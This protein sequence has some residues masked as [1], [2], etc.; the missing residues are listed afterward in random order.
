MLSQQD[1]F[2]DL[3]RPTALGVAQPCDWSYCPLITHRTVDDTLTANS[4]PIVEP[5]QCHNPSQSQGNPNA[6]PTDNQE[7]FGVKRSEDRT[8]A[9][10]SRAMAET[11]RAVA[12]GFEPSEDELAQFLH[13]ENGSY[14]CLCSDRGPCG[15]RFE[16][17]HRAVDHVRGHFGLRVYPCRGNCGKPKW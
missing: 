16:R 14:M 6:W 2:Q 9:T 3:H 13:R 4:G 12:R 7:A 10:L 17:R 5:S 1:D 11:R 8:G 15:K